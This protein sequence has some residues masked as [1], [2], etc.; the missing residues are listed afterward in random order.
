[1]KRKRKSKT[2]E[3]INECKSCKRNRMNEVMK[4]KQ[5]CH[6]QVSTLKKVNSVRCLKKD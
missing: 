5:H 2:N 1:M 6:N 3:K 4:G